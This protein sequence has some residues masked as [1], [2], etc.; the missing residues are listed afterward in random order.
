M[1]Q[2]LDLRFKGG[3]EPEISVIFNQISYDFRSN[4]NE[5]VSTLSRPFIGDLDWWVE[6]PASRNTYASPFYHNLCCLLLVEYLIKNKM[7]C[8]S[9][10]LV[11]NSALQKILIQLFKDFDI[12]DFRLIY[13]RKNFTKKIKSKLTLPFLIFK[14]LIQLLISRLSGKIN[15]KD[16]MGKPLILVDT[17]MLEEYTNI[18]RWYGEFWNNLSTDIKANT[19]FI[20]TIVDTPLNKMHKVYKKLRSNPR[21]FIIKEDFLNFINI[22]KT[23]RHFLNIRKMKIEPFIFLNYDIGPL[24]KEELLNNT[25]KF[26]VIESL[27]NFDF[28]RNLRNQNIDVALSIDWF[29]GHG[30]DKSWSFAF[31]SFYPETTI[32]GYRPVHGQ[33]AY[34]SLFPIPIE[35][36]AKC[37]PDEIAIQAR[38]SRKSLTEFFPKLDVRIIPSFKSAYVWG[39]DYKYNTKKSIALITLPISIDMSIEMIKKIQRVKVLLKFDDTNN[40]FII[41]PHPTQN[42]RLIKEIVR[43]IDLDIQ[44]TEDKSFSTALNNTAVLLTDASSTCLE[45]LACGIPVIIIPNTDGLSYNPL[46]DSIPSKICTNAKTTEEIASDLKLFLYRDILMFK[47]LNKIGKKIRNDFFEPIT[48]QGIDRFLNKNIK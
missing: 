17:F 8:Y 5:I 37:L 6:G 25:D 1:T 35:Y 21:N 28:V 10:V 26:S 12:S 39:F 16:I 31:H 44:V 43:K 41:K 38:G 48:Q 40:P 33:P 22:F 30:V 23:A 42:V 45:A 3:F 11:N 18:D 46:P 24:V 2:V 7:F 4:F 20:P 29:E 19:Y 13:I 34:L 27:L 9:Q 32:V 15:S 36:E 14:K 47:E